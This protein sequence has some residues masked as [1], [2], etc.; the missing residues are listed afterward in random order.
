L[1]TTALQST[2]GSGATSPSAVSC[3][4]WL[5]LVPGQYC[6]GGKQHLGR[7]TKADCD[8]D[9][10]SSLVHGARAALAAGAGR[11]PSASASGRVKSLASAQ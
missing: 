11:P 10:R 7:I 2:I 9:L 3:A 6:S 1:A 4:P 5:G 8:P